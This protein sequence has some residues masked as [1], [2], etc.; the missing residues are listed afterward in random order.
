MGPHW[1]LVPQVCWATRQRWPY[2]DVSNVL[3]CHNLTLQLRTMS[4]AATQHQS[5]CAASRKHEQHMRRLR[6]NH[7]L[8]WQTTAVEQPAGLIETP[9]P[10]YDPPSSL[11]PQP[12]CPDCDCS[13]C[14]HPPSPGPSPTS[15]PPSCI[16]SFRSLGPIPCTSVRP[17]DALCCCWNHCCYTSLPCS[18][19][20]HS[21]P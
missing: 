9:S 14:K 16:P 8:L 19:I 15:C 4:R 13:H 11:A 5:P 10:P 18:P 12:T 17:L 6:V 20:P 7:A 2:P 3:K 21:R 1:L